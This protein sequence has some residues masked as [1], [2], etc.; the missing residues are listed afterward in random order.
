MI[1]GVCTRPESFIPLTALAKEAC[2]QWALGYTP[3]DF[4]VVLDLLTSGRVNAQPMIT[5]VIGFEDLAEKFEKLRKP[6][7]ECKILLRPRRD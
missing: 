4:E 7:D 2:L 5:H 3:R 6:T 1:C